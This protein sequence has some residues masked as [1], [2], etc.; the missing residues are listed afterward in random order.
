[1]VVLFDADSLLYA[2]VY[3]IM[4][5]P[6]IKQMYLSGYK[7]AEIE[8]EIIMSSAHRFDNMCLD[9][10]TDIEETG[11]D[12]QSI[13]YY[14]TKCSK[15]YRKSIF[16]DYKKNRKRNKWISKLRDYLIE[17]D[18]SYYDELFEADDLIAD[19]IK[20]L[21]EDDYMIATTDKDVKM[22][23]GYHY[24]YYRKPSKKDELI[25]LRNGLGYTTD[26][27]HKQFFCYQ[28]LAGDSCDG[29]VGIKGIGDKKAR[30]LI[31][32][33]HIIS[34]FKTVIETYIE[35]S[36]LKQMRINRELIYLGTDRKRIK[37]NK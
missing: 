30:N 1:M 7:R 32:G 20:E 16:P 27:G 19:R 34:M 13:E 15:S 21:E 6:E 10:F 33:K 31:K 22:L 11:C 29:I 9:I 25:N 28:M 3:K 17:G 2:S 14:Y 8:K 5:F 18:D 35:K 12:I 37:Q 23:Q 24:N 26:L 36:D 4:S